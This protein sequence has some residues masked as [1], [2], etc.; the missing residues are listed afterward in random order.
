[1][2]IEYAFFELEYSY[3]KVEYQEYD[4]KYS[5]GLLP[6]Q[7]AK[8]ETI[9]SFSANAHT[10]TGSMTGHWSDH[11]QLI[12]NNLP[13][14][15]AGRYNQT[16]NYQQFLNAFGMGEEDNYSFFTDTRKNTFL[17]TVDLDDVYSGHICS[18]PKELPDLSDRQGLNLIYNSDF[19]IPAR[20]LDSTPCG[21]AIDKSS[22]AIAQLNSSYGLSA[23]NALEV[24]T[25]SGQYATAYQSYNLSYPKG[26]DLV[27]SAMVN[28]PNNSSSTDSLAS[29][30]ASMIMEALYI[31][32]SVERS[33]VSIPLSTTETGYLET[34][35]TGTN[36]SVHIAQWQKINT[37][38]TLSKPSVLIKC[39]INSNYSNNTSNF[40]FYTDCVQLEQGATSTRWKKSDSDALP[41]ISSNRNYLPPRYNVYSNNTSDYTYSAVAL[42]SNTSYIHSRPKT[43]LYYTVNEDQFYYQAVPTRLVSVN[44]SAATGISRNIK[45]IVADKY[46]P[47][48]L[49]AQYIVDPSDSSKIKKQS[50]ELNDDYGSYAIAERDYFGTDP[51]EYTVLKDHYSSGSTDYALEIRGLTFNGD[52]IIAFCKES[53]DSNIYY[54]FKFIKPKKRFNGDYFECMQDYRVSD[55]T[56]DIF[57]GVETGSVK[58]NFVSKLEGEK[59]KFIIEASDGTKYEALFAYDYYID[60]GN[61]QFLTREKYDQICIT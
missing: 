1:M 38:I 17:D 13:L 22:G 20:A 56:K 58:F 9:Y 12:G 50:F 23:G 44:T 37:K 35:L 41:W 4:I 15:H 60:A 57:T 54:T 40:L 14:W 29:G 30:S 53:I 45:G 26:Q 2:G 5:Y 21:W 32:G 7:L 46:D 39:Y 11:T 51:Y 34:N 52:N 55:S 61:G 33:S 18:Y 10:N 42:N 43:Q 6:Y 48:I 16:S 25:D 24:K 47:L 27:L 59:N 49:N 36:T 19:S 28:V 8:I 31:D 3:K